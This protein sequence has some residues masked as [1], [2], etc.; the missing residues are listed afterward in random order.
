MSRKSNKINLL[1]ILYEEKPENKQLVCPA[2]FAILLKAIL[3]HFIYPNI[4]SKS[5]SGV[6][7]GVRS[8]FSTSTFKILGDINTGRLGPI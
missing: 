3:L 8:N 2:G 7:I 6:E 5:A 1:F 4:F